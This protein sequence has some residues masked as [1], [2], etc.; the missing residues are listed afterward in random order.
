MS[1]LKSQP[2]QKP[3]IL[4]AAS[5]SLAAIKFGVLADSLSDWAE[6]RVVA[7]KSALHF[8]NRQSLPPSIKF[9]VDEDEWSSWGKIG[10]DVLHIELRKWADVMV[11]ASLSA[12][13]LAKKHLESI[14]DLGILVISPIPKKLV[15]GDYGNGAMPEPSVI[16]STLRL[17]MYNREFQVKSMPLDSL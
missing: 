2:I 15:C 5:G 13:T 3:R 10:D 12:N 4:L 11:I 14:K 8:I 17:A 9:Y 16:E 1:K 7:T 6:V